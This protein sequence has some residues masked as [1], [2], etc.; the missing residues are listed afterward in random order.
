MPETIEDRVDRVESR[1]SELEKLPERVTAVEVQ[2]VQLRAEMRDEFSALREE[3]RA[4]DTE[5]RREV[6]A[7]IQEL[8][9]TMV[10]LNTETRQTMVELNAETRR[11]LVE[12]NAE[13]RRALVEL[14]TEMNDETRRHMRVLHEDVI[15]RLALIQEGQSSQLHRRKRKR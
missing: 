3:I 2:I 5:T 1:V 4:G 15:G 12:L 10:A 6:R 8:R 9:Q 7:E 13:T 11:A 14:L